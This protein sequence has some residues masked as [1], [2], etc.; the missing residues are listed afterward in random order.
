MTLFITIECSQRVYS[1]VY[2]NRML[3]EHAFYCMRMC[4]AP[5]LLYGKPEKINFFNR[6]ICVCTLDTNSACAKKRAQK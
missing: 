6:E 2:D 4:R 1:I 5:E 3:A